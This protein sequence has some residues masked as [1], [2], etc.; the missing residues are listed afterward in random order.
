M[1][2]RRCRRVQCR[3]R[4]YHGLQGG[5]WALG[6]S[7]NNRRF[8]VNLRSVRSGDYRD[9]GALQGNLPPSISEQATLGL[10]L[11][12]LGTLSASYLR[13]LPTATRRQPLRQPVLVAQLEPALV[14]L[15]VA[16][17]EPGPERR[18]QHL[19]VADRQSGQQP[20]GQPLEPTQR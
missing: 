13:P 2:A 8:N 10:D 3:L 18:P 20:P 15:P 17:P 14:G 9:L 19:P 6:Y 12:R 4:G 1:A 11:L 16:E 5:Q 7:W